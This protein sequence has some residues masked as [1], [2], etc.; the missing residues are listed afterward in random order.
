[1]MAHDNVPL[2]DA[3]EFEARLDRVM[4]NTG[5]SKNDA[6]KQAKAELLQEKAHESGIVS[7]LENDDV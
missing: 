6:M 7:Y 1:M 3:F 4:Q 2:Y 5:K